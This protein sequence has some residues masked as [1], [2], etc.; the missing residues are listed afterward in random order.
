MQLW[1]HRA[2][3]HVLAGAAR[4]QELGL[5]QVVAR[6]VR[7]A[8]NDLRVDAEVRRGRGSAVGRVGFVGPR[9]PHRGEGQRLA[10]PGPRRDDGHRRAV[11]AVRQGDDRRVARGIGKERGRRRLESRDVVLVRRERTLA[12]LGHDRDPAGD[13]DRQVLE[14]AELDRRTAGG[15]PDG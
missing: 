5:R 6:Q 4:G 2:V 12:R 10:Q 14:V 8:V 3:G 15:Y 7:H 1:L 13:V 11:I 9:G